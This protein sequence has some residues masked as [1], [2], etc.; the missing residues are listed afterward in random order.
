MQFS[1]ISSNDFREYDTKC[2]SFCALIYYVHIIGDCMD[3]VSFT[4]FKFNYPNM[5][6]LGGRNDKESVI[7]EL[8]MHT[9]ILFSDQKNSF[10]YLTL[11]NKLL[12]LD[13]NLKKIV[14]SEGGINTVVKYRKYVKYARD[15]MNI[16]EKNIPN[17]LRE[18]EFSNRYTIPEPVKQNDSNLLVRLVQ[19]MQMRVYGHRLLLIE[20]RIFHIL[21]TIHL[22]QC[23][24]FVLLLP[25]MGVIGIF[26]YLAEPYIY[27]A[28]AIELAERT[29]G[30]EKCFLCQLLCQRFVA[31]QAYEKSIHCI[32]MLPVDLLNSSVTSCLLSSIYAIALFCYK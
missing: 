2:D 13:G 23:V 22:R 28:A 14:Q 1:V 17:L 16:L 32:E 29:H 11:K 24:I 18:E 5:M 31:A 30:A 9:E 8:L 3:N 21:P 26:S 20:Q 12:K 27:P 6:G 4:Q 15:L 25:V 10:K 19:L 7:A